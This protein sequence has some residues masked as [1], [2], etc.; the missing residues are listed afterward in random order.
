MLISV[1]AVA[2]SFEIS[3]NTLYSDPKFIPFIKNNEK[4]ENV[5]MFDIDGFNELMNKKEN[6]LNFCIDMVNFAEFII[7]IIGETEFYE[8]IPSKNRQ[9]IKRGFGKSKFSLSNAE[10]IKQT[11]NEYYNSY[12]NYEPIENEAPYIP[13]ED[14]VPLTQDFIMTNYWARQKTS[15]EIA[16]ELNVPE[17]WIL[18]EIKRLGLQKNKNGIIRKGGMKGKTLTKEER[19]KRQ[20]QPHAK[21]IVRICPKTFEILE[22]YNSQGAVERYG[23]SRENVRKAIKSGGLS[24]GYLWA[25][26]GLE[27]PTINVAKRKGNLKAKLQAYQYK[28]PSKSQLKSLYIDKD[29]TAEECAKHFKCHKTTIAILASKYGLIKRTEKISIST[30]KDLYINKKLQAKEIAAMYGH[31]TSTISTYLSKN[32][33]KRR[34]N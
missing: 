5:S 7:D 13:F 25:F 11:F 2:T 30:L 19:E 16:Q 3:L 15:L 18:S 8:K 10:M 23:Y 17:G 12:E 34:A 21:P 33:I 6:E 14:R 9:C 31:K 1:E 20:N 29:L 32:G 24:K 26:K 22:E 4:R 27:Q 28:K